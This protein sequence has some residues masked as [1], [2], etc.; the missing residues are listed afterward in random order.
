MT[1]LQATVRR[2]LTPILLLLLAGGYLVI[3]GNCFSTAI[4]TAHNSSASPPR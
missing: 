3:L 4:G 1:N 2:H